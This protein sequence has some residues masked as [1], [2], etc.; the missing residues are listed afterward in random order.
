MQLTNLI[1]TIQYKK[2]KKKM[3]RET[4]NKYDFPLEKYIF[5]IEIKYDDALNKMKNI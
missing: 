1:H 3:I 2:M 5:S 4:K